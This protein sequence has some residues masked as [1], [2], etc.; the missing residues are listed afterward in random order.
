[1]GDYHEGLSEG[2]KIGRAEMAARV[3]VPDGWREFI[4]DCAANRNDVHV[5]HARCERAIALLAASPTPAAKRGGVT[6]AEIFRAADALCN[7]WD[8]H[9][10]FAVSLAKTALTA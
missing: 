7:K 10:Q 4:A 6:E 9:Y 2:I 1:M 8:L 3:A 5:T